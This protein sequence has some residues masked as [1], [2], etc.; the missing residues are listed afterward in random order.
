[1]DKLPSSSE[2]R[3]NA[4]DTRGVI[5]FPEL[6]PADVG[7]AHEHHLADSVTFGS[8]A[9]LLIWRSLPS[10]VITHN[11]MRLP[12][13][14]GAARHLEEKGWPLSIRTTGGGAF[15][16]APGTVQLA[17]LSPT[18]RD[19]DTIDTVYDALA[20]LICEALAGLGVNAKQGQVADAFCPG[21][22][23]IV[24]EGRKVAGMA[25]HWRQGRNGRC[26]VAAASIIADE[27]PAVLGGVVNAFYRQAG[28][29][30]HCQPSAVTSLR[31]Q[32]VRDGASIPHLTEELVDQL[33]TAAERERERA[34]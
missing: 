21:G 13:F 26:I 32:A 15:P 3:P 2:P 18:L 20:V 6:R 27:D 10:L 34:R 12:N 25:Q 31:Q 33:I 5:C 4:S 17:L 28:S 30:Y 14:E 22:H 16:V 11:D 19:G 8:P 1:V 9:V 29:S 7:I 23:D 24:V